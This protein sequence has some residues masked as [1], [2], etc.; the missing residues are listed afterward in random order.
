MPP[1]NRH[2][3]TTSSGTLLWVNTYGGASADDQGLNIASDCATGSVVVTGYFSSAPST[4]GPA[5][6]GAGAGPFTLIPTNSTKDGFVLRVSASGT[7]EWVYPVSG[8]DADS[9]IGL[10]VDAASG[11]ALVTGQSCSPSLTFGTAADVVLS[12][13]P[14]ADRMGSLL[15]ERSSSNSFIARARA[16]PLALSIPKARTN[17]GCCP[18]PN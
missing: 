6:A 14:S 4:F 5:G 10:A 13:L 7:S 3:Q 9:L 12:N 16:A 11:D 1:H 17:L 15:C 2:R 8:T 18:S